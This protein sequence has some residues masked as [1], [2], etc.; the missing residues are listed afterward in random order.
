MC[1]HSIIHEKMQFA[2]TTSQ[3]LKY[4]ELPKRNIGFKLCSKLQFLK[5]T[6]KCIFSFKYYPSIKLKLIHLISVVNDHWSRTA[7]WQFEETN[8]Q[9]LLSNRFYNFVLCL[10]NKLG[11]E[12]FESPLFGLEMIKTLA[13]CQDQNPV[14]FCYCI[15]RKLNSMCFQKCSKPLHL[16][17]ISQQLKIDVKDVS[18][19][20][21]AK[22]FCSK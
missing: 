3:P 17:A 22:F 12:L 7:L 8:W 19:I 10:Q 13:Y 6:V 2:C 16:K 4:E 21:F 5:I 9:K 20:L 15:H 11:K 14:A 18:Q 1:F